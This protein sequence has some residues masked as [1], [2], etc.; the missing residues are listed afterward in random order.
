MLLLID[1]DRVIHRWKPTTESKDNVQKLIGISIYIIRYIAYPVPH[2][3]YC[4]ILIKII[5]K[6]FSTH[7]YNSRVWYIN[8]SRQ[9]WT[10]LPAIYYIIRL[11]YW[12]HLKEVRLFI[13]R[14]SQFQI[15][16]IYIYI[17]IHGP[18]PGFI[19]G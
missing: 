7:F 18:S 2:V 4:I 12:Y 9:V 6:Y 13:L 19:Y 11:I 17:Y 1:F 5:D 16:H 3:W 8:K 15:V 10:G 14:W